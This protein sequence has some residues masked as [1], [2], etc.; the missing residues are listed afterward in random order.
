MSKLNKNYLLNL[1]YI[2]G[3]VSDDFYNYKQEFSNNDGWYKRY[4]LIK[5]KKKKKRK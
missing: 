2:A 4:K 3:F 5:T 1:A